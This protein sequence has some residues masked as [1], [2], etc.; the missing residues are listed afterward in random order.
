M[1]YQVF[2][3]AYIQD[4]WV[5]VCLCDVDPRLWST[6]VGRSASLLASM[7]SSVQVPDPVPEDD[8]LP[9]VP[10]TPH[11]ESSFTPGIG[12]AA[13]DLSEYIAAI[14]SEP[15]KG[16]RST[17]WVFTYRLAMVTERVLGTV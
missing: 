12:Q 4:K 9:W 15:V 2:G 1:R 6:Y 8:D 16:W 13:L 5:C 17:A 10:A 3:T 14:D 11:L 7:H